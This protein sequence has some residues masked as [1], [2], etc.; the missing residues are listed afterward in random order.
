MKNICTLYLIRHGETEWNVKKLLQ[1][2]TDIPLN[3]KGEIQARQLARKFAQ[4]HF[5]AVF[6]SDLIRAKRT[7]EIVTQEKKLAIFT[8]KALRER[9]FGQY[10]GRSFVQKKIST[11]I[12][13]L[14]AETKTIIKEPF[15]NNEILMMRFSTFLRE[16]AVAYL[17]KTVLIVSHGGPM[18]HFLARLDPEYYREELGRVRI[19]NLAY[20]KIKSDGID[21]FLE[22]ASGVNIER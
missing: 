9:N 16:T 12:G 2:H 7:A 3:K 18:R 6:S 4:T 8:T 20:F 1:G 22:E 14:E 19:N 17:G 5:D 10:E 13:K 11:L 21:F 15:E